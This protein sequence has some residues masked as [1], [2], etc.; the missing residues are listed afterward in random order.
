MEQMFFDEVEE[1]HLE[2]DMRVKENRLKPERRESSSSGKFLQNGDM[3]TSAAET[4]RD[5]GGKPSEITTDKYRAR[6]ESM[7]DQFEKAEGKS[8]KGSP[9]RSPTPKIKVAKN[10]GTKDSEKQAKDRNKGVLQRQNSFDKSNKSGASNTEGQSSTTASGSGK[11]R[12]R[13]PVKVRQLPNVPPRNNGRGSPASPSGRTENSGPSSL[14]RTSGKGRKLPE[15]PK[16]LLQNKL[17]RLKYE[18]SKSATRVPHSSPSQVERGG[19]TMSLSPRMERRKL[20]APSME[21]RDDS[22]H[23]PPDSG[24]TGLPGDGRS[25]HLG[26]PSTYASC[27]VYFKKETSRSVRRKDSNLVCLPRLLLQSRTSKRRTGSLR[28]KAKRRA[29][30]PY[31]RLIHLPQNLH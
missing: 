15:V 25:K 16:I 11:S 1:V 6:M 21:S 27:I 18:R 9:R 19:S 10:N 26:D 3:N 5:T 20:S 31:C 7:F 28:T 8:P 4:N 30:K 2:K 23:S 17:G 22:C 24:R 29:R 13:S 14:G 12:G